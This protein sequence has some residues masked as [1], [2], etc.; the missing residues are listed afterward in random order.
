MNAFDRYG[1][2][3]GD[4]ADFLLEYPLGVRL[5]VNRS[6]SIL[7]LREVSINFGGLQA[8]FRLSIQV[9][10]GQILSII[11]PNGAGKTTAINLIT[12]IYAPTSGEILF[13]G[14][15]ITGKRSYQIARMGVARTFQNIQVFQNMTVRE[16]VMVGMHSSTRSE[17]IRCLLRTPLVR[18]EEKIIRTK[19]DET[20]CL[21]EISSKADLLA[22]GLP[23]GIQKKVDIA[24]TLATHPK[25][26]LLD[27]PVAGLNL[28]ETEDISHLAF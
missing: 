16:N 17:F 21:M 2:G 1:H 28:Q 19:A 7:E 10:E 5:S 25:L 14:Q 23:Y 3:Q 18:K 24:R 4:T 8:I 26:L 13:L 20:L 15:G 27:E 22:A 11:G 9:E 6:G 12:G